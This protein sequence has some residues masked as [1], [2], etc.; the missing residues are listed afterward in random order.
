M[1][2]DNYSTD[3]SRLEV[4]FDFAAGLL[5]DEEAAAVEASLTADERADLAS[6][7]T[8]Q[9]ALAE[10]PEVALTQIERAQLRSAIQAQVKAPDSGAAGRWF[11]NLKPNWGAIGSVAAS[12][13]LVV[14]AGTFV[15]SQ[16][17]RSADESS[18][19]VAA[20]IESDAAS[21]TTVAA[22]AEAPESADMAGDDT[23]S[24]A[25]SL[26]AIEEP[27]EEE[28]GTDVRSLSVFKRNDAVALLEEPPTGP[29]L[30]N[31]ETLECRDVI[32]SGNVTYGYAGQWEYEDGSQVPAV[33]FTV[34]AESGPRVLA[35]ESL[36]CALILDESR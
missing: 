19:Q 20:Q 31:P 10:A 1:T 4:L 23:M 11:Q 5:S 7:H 21:E 27:A 32:E 6:Q 9:A 34:E 15:V 18:D 36:T 30:Y 22:S 3:D 25:G 28:D 29:T 17:G 12:L 35:F 13:V 8:V 24:D 14:V 26:Q 2:V 16:V 33:L